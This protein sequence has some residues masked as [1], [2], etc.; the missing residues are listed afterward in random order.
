[1]GWR[2]REKLSVGKNIFNPSMEIHPGQE[3][4]AILIFS[5]LDT[6]MST[7][8]F[9]NFQCDLFKSESRIVEFHVLLSL[10]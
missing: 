3:E 9:L 5:S 2:S 7:K 4:K 6:K 10:F 1:V 8:G